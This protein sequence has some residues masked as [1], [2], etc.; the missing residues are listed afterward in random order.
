MPTK[1]QSVR[2]ELLCT[3]RGA[4]SRNRAKKRKSV[5][6]HKFVCLAYTDQQVPVREAEKDE[7]FAAGLGEK[8]IVFDDLF[9]SAEDFRDIL[10]EAFPQLRDGG[11]YQ[12]LKCMPNSRRL[13]ALSGLVMQSPHKLKQRVGA[14][15]TY[16]RPLQK[17]LDTTPTEQKDGSVS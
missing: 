11:G 4:G 10:Y 8:E 14:A 13:E 12:L 17:K 3:L 15:R 2:E 9:A 6:K 16:I 1:R 5:W 7:L